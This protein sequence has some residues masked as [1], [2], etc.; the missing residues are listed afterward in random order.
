MYC[1]RRRVRCR[2]RNHDGVFHR[3]VFFQLAN[4]VGNRGIL[5]AD[6]NIDTLNA[7]ALLID[8]GID[9]HGGLTGLAVTN[10]QLALTTTDRHHGVDGLE[11]G[12]HRLVN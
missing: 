5:L 10:N 4:D 8:D 7:G 2:R 3:T 11:T 6:R 1:M 9:S 12:L